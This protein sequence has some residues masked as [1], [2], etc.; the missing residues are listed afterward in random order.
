MNTN[1]TEPNDSDGVA[2]PEC[3]YVGDSRQSVSVH[4]T[5]KHEGVCPVTNDKKTCES[6]GEVFWASKAQ[7]EH[8]ELDHCSRECYYNSISSD[9]S[10]NCKECGKEFEAVDAHDYK[11]RT[12]CSNEC[13]V[14]HLQVAGFGWT[15]TQCA[16]CGEGFQ[17]PTHTTRKFCSHEC[18]D[19]WRSQDKTPLKRQ[20]REME[21]ARGWRERV[22]QNDGYTCQNCND[23]GGDLN[24]HHETPLSKLVE[25]VDSKQEIREHKLFDNLQ[26]GT[27]LCE[28]CHSDVH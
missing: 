1:D 20:W 14:S 3:D 17:H 28:D 13:R 16:E 11:T 4:W 23:V 7:Q 19:K 2:C 22:F 5:H 8:R 25:S 18:H 26:N 6:C 15:I 24:A 10:L 27:T 21:K 12:F 9:H